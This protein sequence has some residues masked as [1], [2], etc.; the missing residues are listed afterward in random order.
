MAAP[1]QPQKKE[2]KKNPEGIFKNYKV[3]GEKLEKSNKSCPKCGSGVLMANHKDRNTC[4]K[5]GYMEKKR[6]E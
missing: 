3:S 6:K 1:Q 4:G 2:V 5:C